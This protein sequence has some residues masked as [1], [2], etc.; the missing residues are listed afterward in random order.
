MLDAVLPHA[1]IGTSISPSHNT[2]TMSLITC[3]GALIAVARLPLE[4]TLAIFFIVCVHAFI[5]VAA[6]HVP[7]LVSLP[8]LPFS[9][10]MLEAVL[11]LASI[12]AS[13]SPLILSIAVW[14]SMQVLSDI[15]VA[16]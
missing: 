6:G 8:L 16:V 12:A 10:A 5:H 9:M 14:F 15:A 4:D 2:I 1:H 7:V 3:V 11:E 13:I